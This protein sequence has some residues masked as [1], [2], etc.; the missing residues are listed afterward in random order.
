MDLLFL[1]I[2]QIMEETLRL[3]KCVGQDGRR[4]AVAGDVEE[5]DCRA[6]TVDFR[7]DRGPG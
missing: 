1:L 6:S 5:S 7:R 3:N 4:D 2:A